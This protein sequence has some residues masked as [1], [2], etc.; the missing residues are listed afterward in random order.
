MEPIAVKRTEA[1]KFEPVSV[2]RGIYPASV[3]AVRKA[4][5][6]ERKTLVIDFRISGGPDS[7]KV[8]SGLTSTILNEKSKLY[9]WVEAFDRLLIPEVGKDFDV[10][11]LVGKACRILTDDRERTDKTGAKFRQSFVKDVISRE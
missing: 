1:A 11:L 8:V 7:G 5:I 2:P 10:Q 9:K 6:Q 3:D 4:M